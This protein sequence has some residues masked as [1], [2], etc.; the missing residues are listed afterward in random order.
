MH[1]RHAIIAALNEAFPTIFTSGSILAVAG[2]LIGQMTTNPII[3]AIGSCLS[4]GTIISIVLVLAVLPQILVLGDN[5]IEHTSF[6]LNRI[7]LSTRSYSGTIRVNGHLRGRVNG[8]MEGT[9]YGVIRG[10]MEAMISSGKAVT[11]EEADSIEEG[12]GINE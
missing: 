7:N 12:S 5:I 11:I 8:T 6:E 9:F 2:A 3:S 10:D 4:R 1:P